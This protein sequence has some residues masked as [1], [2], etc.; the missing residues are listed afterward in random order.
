MTPTRVEVSAGVPRAHVRLEVGA[1]APRLISRDATRAHV[2]ITAA[3]MVL[4]GGDEVHISIVV[5]PGCALRIDDVGGTVAYKGEPSSWTMEAHIGDGG[6][7]LWHGLPFIVTDAAHVER[8]SSLILGSEARAVIRETLVFGRH[9]ERGGRLVSMLSVA[10]TE[11]PV[12]LERLDARGDDPEPGILGRKRVMD[13]VT[14]V[15][16]RPPPRRG[17]LVLAEPGAMARH[18]SDHTHDSPLDQVWDA[19]A[20]ACLPA[21]RPAVGR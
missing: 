17:D 7:L 10:D 1:L 8:R 11:G 9:G 5:G 16:Y 18:L 4:L 15:G 3:G 2:A 19:W 12:L 6:V 14:A 20:E 13:T 21:R